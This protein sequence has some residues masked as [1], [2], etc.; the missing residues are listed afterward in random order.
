[1]ILY[2]DANGTYDS[3]AGIEVGRMLQELNYQ[4]FELKNP[5]PGKR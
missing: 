4:F 2:A 3:R 5:A 1:V